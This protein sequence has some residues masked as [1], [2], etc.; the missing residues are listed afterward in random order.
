MKFFL[1]MSCDNDA[2]AEDGMLEVARILKETAKKAKED[3]GDVIHRRL[4]RKLYDINGNFVGT[5]RLDL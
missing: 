4:I 1:E 5:A 2:F 3:G